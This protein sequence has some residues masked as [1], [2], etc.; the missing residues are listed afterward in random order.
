MVAPPEQMGTDS[1]RT[2]Q[3]K[4]G[5]EWKA[6][7]EPKAVDR[8]GVERKVTDGGTDED[9]ECMITT[10]GLHSIRDEEGK[11]M[12]RTHAQHG[13]T[14]AYTEPHISDL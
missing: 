11:V 2:L 1:E 14:T 5:D 9:Q 8:P 13:P 6:E 10:Q 4:H 12:E 3:D 7:D